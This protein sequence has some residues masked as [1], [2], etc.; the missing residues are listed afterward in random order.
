MRPSASSMNEYAAKQSR[1]L[2]IL[3]GICVVVLLGAVDWATGYEISFSIFYLAP[4]CFVAWYAGRQAGLILALMGA[5][6][7]LA[8]DVAAGHPFGHFLIPFWNAVVR[9]GFYVITVLIL[10]RLHRFLDEQARLIRE[11][12]EA[13][14]EVK[15]LGGLIPIC[16]WC[17]KI[18]DDE[19][20]WQQ[21]ETYITEHTEASFTHSICPECKAKWNEERR[22]NASG[23]SALKQF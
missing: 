1:V 7:W 9:L 18:R 6:V 22:K 21:V 5:A 17:K 14:D 15:A 19:G 23:S 4:I 20:Y 10:H 11:L 8:A 13:R 12:Q 3:S 2:V 16:A